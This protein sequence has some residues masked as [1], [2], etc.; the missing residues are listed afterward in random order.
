[1]ENFDSELLQW[2]RYQDEMVLKA[3]G[4]NVR[5]N[6]TPFHFLDSRVEIRNS[7]Q[8]GRHMVAKSSIPDQTIILEERPFSLSM[9][10]NVLGKCNRDD[11]QQV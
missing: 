4:G 1:V 3:I 7:P 6:C 10:P 9:K 11:K 2:R 8:T 5:G